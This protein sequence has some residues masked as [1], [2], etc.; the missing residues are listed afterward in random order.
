MSALAIFELGSLICALAQSSDMF[1]AGRA[2]SG[3]GG[4]GLLIGL[5]T[6]IASSAPL[7]KRPFMF[8]YYST[9]SIPQDWRVLSNLHCASANMVFFFLVY[10]G[11]V[12]GSASIG[13]VLGPVLGGVFT[14]EATWRWCFYINLPFGAITGVILAFI[15]IP[16][17][18]LATAKATWKQQVKRLDL[19]GFLLF[20]PTCTMLLLALEWGGTTYSWKSATIIGLF[21]GSV[22]LC[23][24]FVAWEY[25]QGDTA[26]ISISV[27]RNRYV[28]FAT[29]TTIVSQGSLLLLTYYLPIWFQVVK[30][31]SPIMGGV[32]YLPSVFSQVCASVLT[33]AL[34]KCNPSS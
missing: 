20:T 9:S 17:G 8:S 13:L 6:I 23:I 34:S 1:I 32:D 27:V 7:H 22:G 10:F 28:V 12:I 19:P 3:M 18:K 31:A 30:N 2:V 33:G 14:E 26:M 21:C 5:I 11:I 16:D 29:I 4:A 15:H 25:R 24:V